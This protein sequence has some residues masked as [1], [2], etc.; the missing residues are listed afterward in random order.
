MQ[1]EMFG[2][3][4]FSELEE[5]LRSYNRCIVIANL[6]GQDKKEQGKEYLDQ[7]TPQERGYVLAMALL[8]QEKGIDEV[9]KYVY[10]NTT[11]KE[12]AE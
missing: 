7:F 4:L 6:V 12:E 9:R 2:Y 8:M 10:E 5:P 3:S 1:N 11:F